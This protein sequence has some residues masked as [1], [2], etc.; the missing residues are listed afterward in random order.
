MERADLR[1]EMLVSWSDDGAFVAEVPDLPGCVSDGATYAEA[2][3]NAEDAARAWIE[4]A[5]ALG[6][7]IPEPTPRSH[8]DA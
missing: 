7:S 8:A 3:A 6:R 1:F 4:T 5:R 2:A